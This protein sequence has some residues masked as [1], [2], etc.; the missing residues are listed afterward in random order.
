M[1]IVSADIYDVDLH[2]WKPPIILRLVTD[3]GIYGLGEFP[4][5]YGDGRGAAI[6]M[7]DEW[8]Q[9]FVLGS[10]PTRIEATWHTLFRRTFWGQGGGPVVYGVAA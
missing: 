7:L 2:P 1:R 8:V 9:R 6:A 5:A 10:D 4:L 3:Q